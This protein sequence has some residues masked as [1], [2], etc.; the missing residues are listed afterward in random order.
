MRPSDTSGHIIA[1]V[2]KSA[3]Q[4]HPPPQKKEL[5]PV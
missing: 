3:T 4:S 5:N 1:S 2:S